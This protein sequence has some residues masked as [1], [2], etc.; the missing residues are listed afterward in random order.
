MKAIL[1]ATSA[2]LLGLS[3]AGAS[4][5]P[6]TKVDKPEGASLVEPVHA[7][8]YHRNCGWRGGRWV[9][10]LGGGRLVVCR[11][12]RPGRAWVWRDEGPRH[13]WYHPRDRRWSFDRW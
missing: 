6:V 8:R 13:G 7:W 1:L 9:V 3:A 11:P 10:D 5:L 12:Y 2:T 4:A